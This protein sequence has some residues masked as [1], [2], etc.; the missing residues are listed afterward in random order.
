MQLSHKNRLIS[1]REQ[2][3]VVAR[4]PLRGETRRLSPDS[5]S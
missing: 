2:A 1:E 4:E 3:E 5:I